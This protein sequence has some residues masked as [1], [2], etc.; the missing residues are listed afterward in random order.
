MSFFYYIN[1]MQ[2]NMKA[3][4]SVKVQ[5]PSGKNK[6]PR[7]VIIGEV[8]DLYGFVG[9]PNIQIFLLPLTDCFQFSS[10]IGL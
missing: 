10:C 7:L 1:D 9:A 2:K 6:Y 5:S 3:V 4:A 8:C